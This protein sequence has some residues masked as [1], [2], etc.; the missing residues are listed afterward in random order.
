MHGESKTGTPS[1][2]AYKQ[3]NKQTNTRTGPRLIKEGKLPRPNKERW[4]LSRIVG[5]AMDTKLWAVVGWLFPQPRFSC[6]L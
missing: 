3:V 5:D 2:V 1:H 4:R 6:K